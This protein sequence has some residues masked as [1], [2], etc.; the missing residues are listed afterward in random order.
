MAQGEISASTEVYGIEEFI[1]VWPRVDPDHSET[2]VLDRDQPR[3]LLARSQVAFI[4]V[5]GHFLHVDD[6]MEFEGLEI[7]VRPVGNL[8]IEGPS[9]PPKIY[10]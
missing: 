8:M 7:T 6:T 2:R 9:V 10:Y 1:S 4:R 5:E 3:V